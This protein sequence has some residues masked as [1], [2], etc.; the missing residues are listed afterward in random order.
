MKKLI[1]LSAAI[2]LGSGML[3]AQSDQPTTATDTGRDP[4]GV[5]RVVTPRHES[6]WGW[7]GLV[8]LVGLAGLRRRPAVIQDHRPAD[9]RR[10]A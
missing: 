4:N 2:V 1:S 7:I 6:N 8:G 10:V 5:T 9:I 3:L